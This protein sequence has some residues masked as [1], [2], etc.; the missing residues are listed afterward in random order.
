VIE[1]LD[2]DEVTSLIHKRRK[3]MEIEQQNTTSYHSRIP[4]LLVLSILKLLNN[5]FET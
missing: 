5:V 2:Y 1:V 3:R 4:R